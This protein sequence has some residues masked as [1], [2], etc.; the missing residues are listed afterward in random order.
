MINHNR[1][2]FSSVFLL[3]AVLL[4]C[5]SVFGKSNPENGVRQQYYAS[6]QL[7]VEAVY[8]NGLLVR[9]RAYYR[10]GKLLS[11]EKYKNGMALS[12]KSYYDN[13][14]LKSL[15]TQKSGV[16]KF[17]HR[18]GSLRVVID[19]DASNDNE[20]LPSSYLLQ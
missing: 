4:F 11:E 17:Y 12:K 7:W 20:N 15:W 10:D 3:S 19:S 13:G 8:K 14:Q 18:D 16:T 5:P 1:F 9:K 2:L 6:G